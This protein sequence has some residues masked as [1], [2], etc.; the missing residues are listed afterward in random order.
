MRTLL[1]NI[2]FNNYPI[3]SKIF[4]AAIHYSSADLSLPYFADCYTQITHT[5]VLEAEG[6]IN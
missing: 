3:Q 2:R 6:I 4:L 1:I 5:V